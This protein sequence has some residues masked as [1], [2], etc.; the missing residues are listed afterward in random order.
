MRDGI[1]IQ[2]YENDD[3]IPTRD[4]TSMTPLKYIDEEH[5]ITDSGA[6]ES[7]T[8]KNRL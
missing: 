4:E 1:Y 3:V 2:T 7:P 6:D 8:I 5:T